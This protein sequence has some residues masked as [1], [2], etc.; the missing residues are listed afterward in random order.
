M[1]RVS[2]DGG[3]VSYLRNL[4]DPLTSFLLRGGKAD[5]LVLFNVNRLNIAS[6]LFNNR[7]ITIPT[8]NTSICTSAYSYIKK[9]EVSKNAAQTV[10]GHQ[11]SGTT[12][13]KL[14]VSPHHF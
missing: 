10:I 9:L 4:S 1:T 11:T 5:T 14:V 7:T 3:L 6:I 8:Y 13:M 2:G 12:L